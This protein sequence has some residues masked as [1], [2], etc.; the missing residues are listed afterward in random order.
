MHVYMDLFLSILGMIVGMT[1]CN[2]YAEHH[3]V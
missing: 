1:I 3:N 2:I